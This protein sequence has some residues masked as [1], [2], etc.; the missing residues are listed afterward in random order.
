MA[1]Q[2]CW[3]RVASGKYVDLNNLKEEDIDL[4]DI[5]V[6]LNN[7]IRFTGHHKDTRPLTV[8]QHSVLTYDLSRMYEPDDEELH[9]ACLIHDFAEAYI[10]DVAT[11]VKKAMGEKWYDFARPI[12]NLV[13]V[14]V[15]GYLFDE[16]V[17]E[18]VKLYDRL[19]LDIE[20]RSMW[21][22]QR[23]KSYWPS[24]PK[25]VGDLDE[26]ANLF[27]AV[28]VYDNVPLKH[29]VEMME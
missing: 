4:L 27:A 7:I 5:E 12:E 21:K 24:V 13:E 28:A 17:R 20:R 26:K 22:D 18:R 25:H 19:S 9:R 23:G 29:L 3:K 11:P 6:A 2:P 14:A 15:N 10:G 8:A 16:Y 1:N